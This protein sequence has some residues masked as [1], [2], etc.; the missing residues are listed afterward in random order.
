[1][2]FRSW[3]ALGTVFG[4]ILVPKMGPWNLKNRAL[5][6]AG[7]VFF[8]FFGFAFDIDFGPQLGAILAQL[9]THKRSQIASNGGRGGLRNLIDFGVHFGCVLGR[10]GRPNLGAKTAPRRPWMRP[11]PRKKGAKRGSKCG[12]VLEP[13]PDPIFDRFW[14]G[15]WRVLGSILG[16]VSVR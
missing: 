5:P 3:I 8:T 15:F 14:G 11:G 10:L 13:V 4:T 7:A 12:S 2:G 6:A 9:G 1:M 16:P